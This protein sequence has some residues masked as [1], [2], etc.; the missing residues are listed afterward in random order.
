M[1]GKAAVAAL[2]MGS[3][4]G[5]GG[6]SLHAQGL[7][8]MAWGVRA[9]FAASPDAF[10]FGVHGNKP[11]ES[12][13]AL[14]FEPVLQIGFGSESVISYNTYELIGRVRYDIGSSGD[15]MPFILA[16][17]GIYRFSVDD[18]ETPIGGFGA[19]QSDV[20]LQVG[21]GIA[22]NGFGVEAVLGIS[23]VS[24]VQ[25]AGRYTFNR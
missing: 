12:V 13:E 7:N 2:A 17:I 8:D 25:V 5:L 11:L 9:G 1:K 10:I 22:K 3:L 4:M 16:G 18:I 6:D 15:A 14:S 19:S 21:G 23:S 24:D 20:G